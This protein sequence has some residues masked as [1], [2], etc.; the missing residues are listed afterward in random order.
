[1]KAY[2][3]LFEL[4]EV[5]EVLQIRNLVVCN[6]EDLEILLILKTFDLGEAVAG[7]IQFTELAEVLESRNLGDPIALN[8]PH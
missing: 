2:P 1:M 3:E 6:L 5:G 7:E 4:G 8:T